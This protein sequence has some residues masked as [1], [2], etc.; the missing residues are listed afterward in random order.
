LLGCKCHQER[1]SQKTKNTQKKK[2][3]HKKK[4]KKKR[5]K[6]KHNKKNYRH[7]EPEYPDIY[8]TPPA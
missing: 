1:L 8:S 5:K 2:E 4:K 6:K 7:V 3:T